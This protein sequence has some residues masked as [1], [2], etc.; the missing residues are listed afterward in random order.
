MTDRRDEA[1]FL[2]EEGGYLALHGAKLIEQGYSPVPIAHGKKAPGFEGWQK[3]QAT[4]KQVKEWVASGFQWAGVG[5]LTKNT[6]AVDIDVRDKE[7]ADLVETWIRENIGDAPLRIGRAPKRLMVFRCDK[8]FR[9][10][11]SA[12]YVDE[13]A[14]EQQIEILA[15]GQQFV[16]FHKHPDTRKPYTWPNGDS[17][18][19]TH[20]SS[21]ITITV[22][23]IEALIAYFEELAQQRGW[24]VVKSAR[25]HAGSAVDLDNPWLEDT[26]AIDISDDELRT[27]LL[28]IP[29][30]DDYE[31][32]FMIGM[33]LYHQFDGDDE[34]LK[35]WHEWA[36]SADNYDAEALDRRWN[37]FS[38]EGKKR[39]PLTARYILRIAKEAAANEIAETTI[40][41]RDMFLAAKTLLDWEQARQ[42]TR[43]AEIDSLSRSGL[44]QIAKTTRDTIT[45]SKTTLI[46]IKKAIRYVP[47]EM[48][49]KP[50]W[51]QAW[52]YNTATDRFFSTSNKI[53]VSQQGFNAMY[54]RNALTKADILDGKVLPSSTA[55]AL[56]LNQYRIQPVDGQ[57]YMPGFDEIFTQTDG[58]FANTYPEHEIPDVPET[59]SARDKRNIERVRKHIA[60]LLADEDEQRM[61]LDWLS[62]V[63]QNPGDHPRYAILLQGVQGDGKT[64]F[65]EMMRN[66][67]GVTNVRMLNAHILHDRFTDW[68]EGSC[69]ACFE[70]VRL[71]NDKNKYEVLNRV[72]PFITNT[73]NEIH[74][75]GEPVRNVKNTQAYL[76][77]TN[78][79]DA[80]PI[81]DTDRRYL[82]LFSRWQQ[83]SAI[84]A[85]KEEHPDYYTN[86]YAAIEESP[87]ALRKWLLGHE[88]SKAFKPMDD[89]PITRA[90]HQMVQRSKHPFIKTLDELI[91]SDSIGGVSDELIDMTALQSA[92][93]SREEDMPAEKTMA[94]LLE[95]YGFERLGR[96]KIDGELHVVWVRNVERFSH[97]G[98]FDTHAVRAY[99]KARISERDEY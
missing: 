15:D 99:L 84:L 57:R 3:S 55:S 50:E 80:L 76:L 16:A 62:F 32:W 18:L 34:G 68:A 79:K 23:Q 93:F 89:A 2:K 94:S 9:K 41:L 1:R 47:K 33:A 63:V 45:G 6:P 48:A 70:E 25:K 58:T 92:F 36:E 61:L 31:Q 72:K 12:K 97:E 38:I 67:M 95:R 78:F 4:V 11:R 91:A 85:F 53:S 56:A 73:T 65:A 49:D 75:K 77:F 64:F 37:G 22:E 30:P 42:A 71:I 10:M 29:H 14:E 39:A 74:P 54:D 19:N 81:D 27:R 8:P 52:V 43:E 87:G 69:L 90:F 82:V 17:P 51:C 5:L 88:Q 66:V 46:E 98:D 40:R 60:H 13:W 26:T 86:L 96:I 35:M 7:V 20:A 28:S 44:A 83:R 59:Y 24:E 21:L